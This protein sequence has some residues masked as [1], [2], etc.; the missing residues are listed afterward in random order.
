MTTHTSYSFVEAGTLQD[1]MPRLGKIVH[2]GQKEIAVFRL[3][4]DRVFALNNQS[5]HKKGGPLCEGMISG[6]YLFDPLYDWKI[7]LTTGLVQAPD[8][9]QV[10]TYPVLVEDNKVRI[11]FPAET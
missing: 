9:G 10:R 2:I 8:S 7:D 1:Y 5:P 6:H 11:G 4:D 3:S